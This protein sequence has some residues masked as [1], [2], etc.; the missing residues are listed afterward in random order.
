MQ[1]FHLGQ[2]VAIFVGLNNGLGKFNSITTPEQWAISS[3]VS[4]RPSLFVVLVADTTAAS[5][6]SQPL[7]SA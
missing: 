1:I 2:S 5:A 6:P 3:K 4:F 7:F